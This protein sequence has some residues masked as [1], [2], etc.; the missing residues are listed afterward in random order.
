MMKQR[1]K[2]F[3]IVLFCGL[4][5]AL[6]GGTANLESIPPDLPLPA[7][8]PSR[9]TW[10]WGA[11]ILQPWARSQFTA[12]MNAKTKAARLKS[13]LGFNTIVIL[14][15][16][17]HN[18]ISEPKYRM[19]E[20]QFREGMAAYRAAGYRV[21]LYTSMMACGSVPEFQSGQLSREHPDWLQRDPQGNP[22]MVYGQPWLCPSTPALDYVL[23]YTMGIVRKYQPDGL[24]LDN[25]EFYQAQAG[26]TCHCADCTKGFRQYVRQRLGEDLTR[27]MFGVAP[28]QLEISTQEGP[29]FALWLRWRNRVWA[30][31]DETFRDHLRQINPAAIVLANTQYLQHD[32]ML[33]TDL[34]YQRED[35]LISESCNLSSRAMS[36]KMILG[37][38]LA[39]GRP[40]WNYIGTFVNDDDYTGLK[41]AG[42]IAPLIAA[43]LAHD[44][45]PWIVD[46]FDEGQTNAQARREMADLLGWHAAHPE[47]FDN[48]PWAPVGVVISLG[49]RNILH[50]PLIPPHLS[51]L[52][53]AGVPLAG[54]RDDVIS[55]KKLT[56][57]RIVTVETAACLDESAARALARW[58]RGGGVLIAARDAGC[59]DE[60]GRKRSTSVLW[61]ALGLD[62]APMGETVEGR[63]KILAP[64]P[65]MFAQEAV[66]HTRAEAFRFTTGSGIEVTPYRESKSLLLQLVRH[67]TVAQSVTLH[68]PGSFHPAKMT[69]QWLTPESDDAPALPLSPCADGYALTLTNVPVY[70]VIKISMR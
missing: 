57:F 65:G 15:P 5:G 30:N 55:L 43:T 16:D 63:G 47:L 70:S 29:L 2:F 32:A 38:A 13:E 28:E 39:E 60:L 11:N 59:Y 9:A 19:T 62:A 46:G 25:S 51:V 4:A 66:N 17:A 41:P 67:E 35:V 23:D 8:P 69:A 58:V 36:E 53:Q 22:V 14:P 40:V 27:R 3:Q 31:V 50:R 7:A 18:A 10:L 34:Q 44:A 33:A 1:L 21:I 45:R 26:W 12:L 68:L 64:E 52:L 61:Q 54:I 37:R 6:H 48:P 24:V 42:V 56:P 49:S 20:A